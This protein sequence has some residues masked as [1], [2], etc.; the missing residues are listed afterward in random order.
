MFRKP[1]QASSSEVFP[2]PSVPQAHPGRDDSLLPTWSVFPEV[3]CR[4]PSRVVT[5]A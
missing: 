1:S 5:A 3:S 2:R 4:R